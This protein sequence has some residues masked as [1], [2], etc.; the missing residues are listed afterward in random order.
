MIAD[1][2]TSRPFASPWEAR[3]FA[4]A[5]KLHEAGVFTWS[6]WAD[7]LAAEIR[8]AQA[9]GDR[10]D[11]TSYY[12]H[13]LATIETLLACKGVVDGAALDARAQ[14]VAA[15]DNHDHHHDEAASP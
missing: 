12:R 13:W 8:H 2:A 5:V 15:H 1:D 14:I 10:D 7:A 4:L 11:G 9:Q 6:E 3:A